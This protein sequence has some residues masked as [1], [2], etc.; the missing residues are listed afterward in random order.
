MSGYKNLTKN[1]LITLCVAMSS[2]CSTEPYIKLLDSREITSYD[3]LQNYSVLKLRVKTLQIETEDKVEVSLQRYDSTPYRLPTGYSKRMVCHTAGT[4]QDIQQASNRMVEY[5][6]LAAPGYY[7]M[8]VSKIGDLDDTSFYEFDVN[9]KSKLYIGELNI[10]VNNMG[11][12][13]TELIKSSDV[14]NESLGVKAPN[15]KIVDTKQRIPPKRVYSCVQL[16]L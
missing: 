8:T 10:S 11:K 12:I 2:S 16:S 3:N 1:L 15:Y 14:V 7:V 4:Y 5:A 6:F 9:S 13:N